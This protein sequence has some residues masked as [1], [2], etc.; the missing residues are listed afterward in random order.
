MHC[1]GCGED[2]GMRVLRSKRVYRRVPF[3]HCDHHV[4]CSADC[5]LR[6]RDPSV[7]PEG[8]CLACLL[9]FGEMP[10]GR[11]YEDYFM[12]VR[13]MA[14]RRF[15]GHQTGHQ[16][17]QGFDPHFPESPD[18]NIRA[19]REAYLRALRAMCDDYGEC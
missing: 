13:A 7:T 3:L 19:L 2:L 5:A 18:R 17:I 6:M 9:L 15:T 14:R 12:R 10:E 8:H 11:T 4:L 1:E 16:T